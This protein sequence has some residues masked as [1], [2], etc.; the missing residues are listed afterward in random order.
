MRKMFDFLFRATVQKWILAVGQLSNNPFWAFPLN[1]EPLDSK[2]PMIDITLLPFVG[3]LGHKNHQVVLTSSDKVL[4]QGTMKNGR[5]R[6]VVDHNI[7]KLSD[8]N[9]PLTLRKTI[10]HSLY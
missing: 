6:G 5:I 4:Y 7:A 2:E 8:W 9:A 3:R 10:V 1:G